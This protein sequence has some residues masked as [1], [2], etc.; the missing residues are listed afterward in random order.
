MRL[1]LRRSSLKPWNWSTRTWLFAIV[2]SAVIS[3]AVSRWIWLWQVPDIALP[4]DV[5]EFI[6]PEIP[7]EQGAFAHYATAVKMLHRAENDWTHQAIGYAGPTD[8]SWDERLDQWL[9]DNANI[10]VEVELGTRREHAGGMS[11]RTYGTSLQALS[12][13]IDPSLGELRS[14]LRLSQAEAFRCERGGGFDEAWRWY[15]AILRL[16][17]HTEESRIFPDIMTATAMRIDTFVWIRKW[18]AH[19]SVTAEQLH[20]AQAELTH[21]TKDRPKLSD[22]IKASYLESR[23]ELQSSEGPYYLFSDWADLLAWPN[24]QDPLF[25]RGS[26]FLSWSA[27]QPELS[28][29]LLRQILVKNLDQVDRPLHLQ[30]PMARNRC[31][32]VFEM[33]PDKRR[34][35][36]QLSAARLRS[37]VEG[38]LGQRLI[39]S[40]LFFR[41]GTWIWNGEDNPGLEITYRREEFNLIALIFELAVHEYHRSRGEF[42]VQ[43]EDLLPDYI[44]S[45]P[46]DPFSPTGAPLNYRR[47]SCNEAN[48][49]SVG[50]D[51]VDDGGE[52]DGPKAH[53]EGYLLS[54]KSEAEHR[55]QKR[56]SQ[57]RNDEAE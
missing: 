39:K 50:I 17:R 21:L 7:K 1:H 8:D 47:N 51:G 31:P 33:E 9:I 32:L 24:S 6:G 48:V 30:R 52:I 49:W 26:H 13:Q 23:N 54:L 28:L 19:P 34:L 35:P 43:I 3:P 15:R 40:G 55:V 53:D 20:Q 27:G 12:G 37:A 11:L 56:P 36:G 38:Q 10:L 5:E 57:Q 41:T 4:F 22:L 45:V 14:L 46:L 18:A 2:F 16:A 42:P 25:S 44:T 29:R